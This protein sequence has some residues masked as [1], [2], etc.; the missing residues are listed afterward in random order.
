[1]DTVTVAF[2]AFLYRLRGGGF[3]KMP[4][5]TEAR[6]IWAAGVAASLW[7]PN[8]DLWEIGVLGVCA[9]L[10]LLIP[11]GYCQNS[12]NW[13]K[14]QRRWPSFFFPLP[15][16]MT[17]SQK[18]GS[19]MR[20]NYDM[21]QMACVCLLR[22]LIVFIPYV[23]LHY[24]LTGVFVSPLVSILCVTLLSPLG[25]RLGWLMPFSLGPHLT[26][27][28]AEWGELFTGVAWGLAIVSL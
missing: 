28:D 26:K 6:A 15:S 24:L 9:F 5:T 27:N 25:Y 23:S 3:I 1:M 13:G 16:Q 2:H 22:S 14:P 21:G 11:H 10:A 4:S 12:G 18:W 8:G 17:W 7:K 20:A 19:V